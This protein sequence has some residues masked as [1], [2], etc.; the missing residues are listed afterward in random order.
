[1]KRYLDEVEANGHDRLEASKVE[2][3][4]N[5]LIGCLY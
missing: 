1:M 3:M 4:A 2:A 5:E